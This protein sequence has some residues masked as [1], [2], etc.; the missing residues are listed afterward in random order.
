MDMDL[1][2]YNL[3]HNILNLC[4]ILEKL[5]FTASEVVLDI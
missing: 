3:G 5:P 4:N 1:S 2:N